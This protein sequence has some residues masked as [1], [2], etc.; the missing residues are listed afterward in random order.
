MRRAMDAL[1]VNEDTP[2][3]DLETQLLDPGW[4]PERPAN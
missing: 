1:G 3:H 4:F 2:R